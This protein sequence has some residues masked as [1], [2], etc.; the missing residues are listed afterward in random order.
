MNKKV[1]SQFPPQSQSNRAHLGS[2]GT[3]YSHLGAAEKSAA[4]V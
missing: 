4:I 1:F 2:G 3:G